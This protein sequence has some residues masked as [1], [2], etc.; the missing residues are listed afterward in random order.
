MRHL[1]LAAFGTTTTARQTYHWLG[2]QIEPYFPDCTIHWIYTSP[3]VRQ[4]LSELS[5]GAETSL[6]TLIEEINHDPANSLVIQSLHVLPGHEFHR[7]VKGAASSLVPTALGMPLLT[8]PSDYQRVAVCLK[9]LMARYPEGGVVVL[10]HGTNHPTWT[11]YPA[12]QSVLRHY[13]GNRVFTGT[14]EMYPDS[15]EVV[16]EIVRSGFKEVVIVPF[17]MVAGMH[18]K[19]DI[20]AESSD[21]WKSQ[22]QSA[23]LQVKL[24]GSGLGML[25]GIADIFCDHIRDAFLTLND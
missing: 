21:S 24:H 18:F 8:S 5:P 17:L 9:P 20:I 6:P 13:Y 12:L 3:K 25:E 1:I 7:L 16:D 15:S 2:S 23:G 10:G 22:L 19:R 4:V 14:L 11:A